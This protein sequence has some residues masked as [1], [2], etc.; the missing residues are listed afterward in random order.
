MYTVQAME[1]RNSLSKTVY[2]MLFTWLVDK[3][4]TTIAPPSDA[5]LRGKRYSLCYCLPIY[6]MRSVLYISLVENYK[7]TEFPLP[8]PR[9]HRFTGYLWLRELRQLELLRAAADQLR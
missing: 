4:N 7:L 6:Y 8:I 9:L 1:K 3:I 2:S 5:A